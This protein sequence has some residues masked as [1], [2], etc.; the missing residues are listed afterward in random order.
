M[1]MC[2]RRKPRARRKGAAA[3][4][5][6]ADSTVVISSLVSGYSFQQL[7]RGLGGASFS[8]VS[9][10]YFGAFPAQFPSSV[11]GEHHIP[12]YKDRHSIHIKIPVLG[13][14]LACSLARMRQWWAE[15]QNKA[16]DGQKTSGYNSAGSLV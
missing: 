1:D 6:A 2:G 9:T 13:R 12:A 8:R 11:I 3:A 7:S 16:C 4:A 15:S 10:V 14:L 5:V